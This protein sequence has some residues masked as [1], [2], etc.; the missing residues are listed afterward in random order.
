MLFGLFD[1]P[2]L[3]ITSCVCVIICGIVYAVIYRVTSNAYYRIV[4]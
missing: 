4:S 3:I 2:R 1:I